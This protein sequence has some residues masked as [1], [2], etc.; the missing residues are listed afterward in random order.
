[1]T[2]HSAVSSS[3]KEI[4][5]EKEVSIHWALTYVQITFLCRCLPHQSLK[6]LCS[7]K[8]MYQQRL[9]SEL[10]ASCILL[11][12][13]VQGVNGRFYIHSNFPTSGI[14]SLPGVDKQRTKPKL[15][16]LKCP[17]YMKVSTLHFYLN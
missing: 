11:H 4:H 6:Y 14:L 10:S 13:M 16:V 2:L 17:L 7:Q 3:K 1:M 15:V 9:L 8:M 12:M 5:R